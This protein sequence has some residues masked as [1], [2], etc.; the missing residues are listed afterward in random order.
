MIQNWK[1]QLIDQ[2]VV[3]SL[4]GTSTTWRNE[5]IGISLILTKGKCQVLLIGKSIPLHCYRLGTNRLESGFAEKDQGVLAETKL[6][7]SQ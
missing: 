2:M 3:P 1:E 4:R 5:Q 7:M 6:P